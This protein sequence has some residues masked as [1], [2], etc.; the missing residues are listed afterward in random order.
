[1]RSGCR[2]CA[3][4]V[5]CC[6]SARIGGLGKRFSGRKSGVETAGETLGTRRNLVNVSVGIAA[7][8]RSYRLSKAF[9][10]YPFYLHDQNDVPS[11]GHEETS[12]SIAPRGQRSKDP[13]ISSVRRVSS[14]FV[15]Y[16]TSL[17]SFWRMN[18]PAFFLAILFTMVLRKSCTI[19]AC[20]CR[21]S[22]VT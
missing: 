16:Y 9:V 17:N 5:N 10:V 21:R 13:S 6:T 18:L 15:Q 4:A 19:V 11:A 7:L 1:M 22:L 12:D 14:L 2:E 8:N 3:S 20:P